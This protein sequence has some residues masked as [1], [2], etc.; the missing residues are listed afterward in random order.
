[1]GVSLFDLC[2][3]RVVMMMCLAGIVCLNNQDF[4]LVNTYVCICNVRVNLF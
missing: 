1:V 3:Y 4:Y 2:F